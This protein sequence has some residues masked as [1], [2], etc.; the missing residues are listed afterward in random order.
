M[1]INFLFFPF[2]NQILE[3]SLYFRSNFFIT[4]PFLDVIVYL[5]ICWV[6]WKLT[7]KPLNTGPP[8][9]TNIRFTSCIHYEHTRNTSI[10]IALV[11]LLLTLSKICITCTTIISCFYWLLWTCISMGTYQSPDLH[12]TLSMKE[13]SIHSFLLLLL[14]TPWKH[15]KNH[16]K[17][18]RSSFRGYKMGAMT[19]NRLMFKK[20]IWRST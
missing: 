14:Y 13:K 8:S 1:K 11:S 20:M 16:S 9:N 19:R 12:K 4:L 3:S 5:C 10:D 15:Q 17:P 6:W 18:T 2:E 7:I